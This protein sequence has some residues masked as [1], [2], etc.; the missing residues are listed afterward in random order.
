M[1]AIT[2]IVLFAIVLLVAIWAVGFLSSLVAHW[3]IP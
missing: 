3:R 2:A 1:R